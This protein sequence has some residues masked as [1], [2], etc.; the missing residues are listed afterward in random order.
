MYT[1]FS[2]S[3]FVLRSQHVRK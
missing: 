2:Q 3:V 1:A